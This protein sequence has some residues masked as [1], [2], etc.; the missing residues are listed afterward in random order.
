MCL[1]PYGQ[2]SLIVRSTKPSR[3]HVWGKSTARLGESVCTDIPAPRFTPAGTGMPNTLH[4]ST[5]R[6]EKQYFLTN[7]SFFIIFVAK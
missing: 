7:V 1:F 4:F 2:E 5:K 3:P 6:H